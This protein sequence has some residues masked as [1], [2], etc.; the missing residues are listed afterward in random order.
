MMNEAQIEKIKKLAIIAE[1]KRIEFQYASMR[2]TPAGAD[3]RREAAVAFALAQAEMYEANENLAAAMKPVADELES[4]SASLEATVKEMS[5]K[6]KRFIDLK[7]PG[8]WEEISQGKE[9]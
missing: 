6:L 7:Y 5:S 9:Y 1:D 8:L 3:E 2:N 4:S